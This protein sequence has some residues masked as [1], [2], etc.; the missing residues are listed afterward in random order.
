[1]SAKNQ[2]RGVKTA[3]L[4]LLLPLMLICEL[5]WARTVDFS[6]PDSEASWHLTVINR[7]SR[8]HN[9]LSPSFNRSIPN[10]YDHAQRVVKKLGSPDHILD[11]GPQP[12]YGLKYL[13]DGASFAEDGVNAIR[14]EIISRVSDFFVSLRGLEDVPSLETLPADLLRFKE[15]TGL[16]ID[17]ALLPFIFDNH[18]HVHYPD[19]SNTEAQAE[20]IEKIESA[21]GEFFKFHY[22][23]VVDFAISEAE[24]AIQGKLNSFRNSF[25][26]KFLTPNLRIVAQDGGKAKTRALSL[27]Q[28]PPLAALA[29]AAVG[30]DCSMLSVPYHALSKS[31][32]VF[33]I[34]DSFSTE[35]APIGYAFVVEHKHKGKRIPVILTVNGPGIVTSHID[36]ILSMLR[37]IWQSETVIVPSA[38]DLESVVNYELI[39]LKL[40]QNTVRRVKMATPSKD[41][42]LIDNFIEASGHGL[43]L[44]YEN[45]YDWGG[46]IYMRVREVESK[47]QL[48]SLEPSDY[49]GSHNV[50][51]LDFRTRMQLALRYGKFFPKNSDRLAQALAVLDLDQDTYIEMRDLTGSR[52]SSFSSERF[53]SLPDKLGIDPEQLSFLETGIL[54]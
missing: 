31:A 14:S 28:I 15:V 27:E 39:R 35:A 11:M 12:V 41:W 25:I 26:E 45:Y 1:M 23:M 49:Y 19:L 16:E 32:K 38:Q 4:W 44:Q 20:L 50:G 2:K 34:R 29:R 52:T 46:P 21:S 22:P 10:L 53:R 17:L 42:Q 48:L 7:H 24:P 51:D 37:D 47:G 54:A 13:D 36:P 30:V 40:G 18:G 3:P 6:D 33:Y 5:T 8:L 43:G 9:N